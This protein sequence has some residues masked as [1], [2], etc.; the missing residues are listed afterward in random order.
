MRTVSLHRRRF[1][2]GAGAAVGGLAGCLQLG[3][4]R[5]E[6]QGTPTGG[7]TPARGTP[8]EARPDPDELT[9][10][11]RLHNAADEARTVAVRIRDGDDRVYGATVALPGSTTRRLPHWDVA[12]GTRTVRAS[13]AGT[14]VVETLSFDVAPTGGRTDGYVAVT[15]RADGTLEVAF[16]PAPSLDAGRTATRTPDRRRA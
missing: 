11:G 5:G 4:G 6:G 13:A 16:A 8:G 2:A 10:G 3:A 14:T 9:I 12:G 15:T 1:V 7:G